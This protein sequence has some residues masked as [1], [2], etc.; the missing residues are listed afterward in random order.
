[1][2]RTF[3]LGLLTF[4]GVVALSAQDEKAA[5]TALQKANVL[6]RLAKLTAPHGSKTGTAPSFVVDPAWPQT[7]PVLGRRRPP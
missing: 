2:N 7:L 3:K 4:A 5:V 1:M 6:Q